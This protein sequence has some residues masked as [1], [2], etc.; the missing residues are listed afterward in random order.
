MASFTPH[1]QLSQRVLIIGPSNIGDAILASDVIATVRA[2]YP[3]AHL[4]LVVGERAHTLFA[5]D[6]RIQTLVDADA[7]DSA[8]GR[9]KLAISL[10]RYQPHVVVDLRHTAYPLLLK[11]LTAWRYLRQAPKTIMH[12]RDRHL[13]KLRVQAPS[14]THAPVPRGGMR[15][16]ATAVRPWSFTTETP[17]NGSSL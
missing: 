3:N 5:G 7:F 12:M 13:W 10:W 17:S 8:V 15:K 2:R 16:D 1:S 11:P 4:T 14:V 6:P 9:L